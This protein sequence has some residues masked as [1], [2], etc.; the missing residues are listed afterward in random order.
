IGSNDRLQHFALVERTNNG[1]DHVH[2][3]ELLPFHVASEQ[4][5]RIRSE[6]KKSAVKLVSE[7]STDWPDRVERLSDKLSLFRRRYTTRSSDDSS[8]A[9]S[10]LPGC[11]HPVAGSNAMARRPSGW[12]AGEISHFRNWPLPAAPTK[13]PPSATTSPRTSVVIG[14]P[15][16]VLPS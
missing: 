9:L 3:F 16:I 11:T 1:S 13:S 5:L 8:V 12:V 10:A 15:V 7:L 4:A 2:Q 6:F 14:Q